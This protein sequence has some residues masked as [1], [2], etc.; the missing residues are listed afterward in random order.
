MS[1]GPIR[2]LLL[3]DAADPEGQPR[4]ALAVPGRRLPVL[5]PSLHA[6]LEEGMSRPARAE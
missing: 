6:A 5:Y 1:A 2:V 4:P 3:P